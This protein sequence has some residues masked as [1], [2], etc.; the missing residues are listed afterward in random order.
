MADRALRRW[1]DWGRHR[2]EAQGLSHMPKARCATD[3]KARHGPDNDAEASRFLGQA[4]FG[5]RPDDITHLRSVGY[6]G[7]FNGIRRAS[8]DANAVSGR[9]RAH[10]S[11]RLPE[12]RHAQ[13]HLDDQFRGTGDP[14]RGGF[15]ANARGDRLRQRVAMALSE[16]FVVS[17]S[18]GTA[19]VPAVG[20]REFL[21]H[22]RRGFVRELSTLLED[23]TKIRRWASSS[24]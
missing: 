12:R 23:V 13:V 21:R 6:E 22:A 10:V 17:N 2:C 19:R 9:V 16:I 20:A 4:T 18:K 24:A 11:R 8:L 14:S 7:W 3:S 1:S 5:A 15:P